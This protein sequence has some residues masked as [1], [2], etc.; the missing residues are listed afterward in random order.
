MYEILDPS[1]NAPR[2]GPDPRRIQLPLDITS[3][4]ICHIKSP[5]DL[6][7]IARTSR[8]HHFLTIPLLYHTVA[9][10]R[11]SRRPGGENRKRMALG[12]LMKPGIAACV[13]VLEFVADDDRE[14]RDEEEWWEKG[15]WSDEETAW[16]VA[17]AGVVTGMTRLD[18]FLWN[19]GGYIHP[20]LYAALAQHRTLKS[21]RVS[22]PPISSPAS[23]S[24]AQALSPTA[25]PHSSSPHKINRP[26]IISIPAFRTLR[27]LNL[28]NLSGI[29][30]L[31][32]DYL[33]AIILSPNLEA[34]SL[35]WRTPTPLRRMLL[36][37]R[38]LKQPRP[39]RIENAFGGRLMPQNGQSASGNTEGVLR[40]KELALRNVI[41]DPPAADIDAWVDM[42]RL[43]KLSLIDC[44]IIDP[45]AWLD[46]IAGGVGGSGDS[47]NS[48][49]SLR[50]NSCA[51]HWV[52]F[53]NT[54]DGLEE[55][56]ILD[57]PVEEATETA[58]WTGFLGTI[59]KH[60]GATLK[61]LRLCSRWNLEKMSV[62]KLFR[63]CPGLLELAFTMNQSQWEILDALMVF[64]PHVRFLHLLDCSPL[65]I[66]EVMVDLLSKALTTEVTL[67]R[68]ELLKL[69]V[70]GFANIV[71]R[72]DQTSYWDE[73][74]MEMIRKGRFVSSD[75]VRDWAGI[76]RAENID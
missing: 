70:F 48:P 41:F 72:V 9:L 26:P 36:F 38:L 46:L 31:T 67:A 30:S 74:R 64:L 57:P 53:L 28:H 16:A 45:T 58:N 10:R 34:L 12:A 20:L 33:P 29:S 69:E 13:K 3:A 54:F 66:E 35:S 75:E 51:S 56:F 23:P 24:P 25:S 76:W 15:Q 68:D 62:S 37:Q 52:T 27:R 49:I 19:T 2:M 55:L 65:T 1:I 17:V 18:V 73:D 7:R 22:H 32:D 59:T 14:S 61:K 11:P 40:L 39:T 71:Y 43:E 42:R 50:I 21:L 44:E 5:A 6:S 60:H 63:A 8:I 47:I 4:I